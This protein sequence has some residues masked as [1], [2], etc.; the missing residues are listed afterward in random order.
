MATD[1]EAGYEI[2]DHTADIGIRMYGN[3]IPELFEQA[4]I[5]ISAVIFHES[6][7]KIELK[8][9]YRIQLQAGDLEQLLVDWL[10]E[11]L[12]IFVTEHIVCSEF[13]IAIE[14]PNTHKKINTTVYS[15]DAYMSGQIIS[16][17]MLMSTCE[18]KAVTY[19]ML[20]IK[21][22]TQWEAQVLFDI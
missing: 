1:I 16:D 7:P 19:H 9:K 8:G 4:A 12:F 17:D 10:N 13:Q 20:Y 5:G 22:T 15:L 14:T 2:F 3:S 6:I 11:L 21:K 18:I